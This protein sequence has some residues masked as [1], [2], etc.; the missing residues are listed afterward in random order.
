VI[1]Q[2]NQVSGGIK[3]GEKGGLGRHIYLGA[4]RT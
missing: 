3:Q 2:G 4:S 1:F